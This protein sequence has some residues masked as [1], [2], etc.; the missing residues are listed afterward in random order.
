MTRIEEK[1]ERFALKYNGYGRGEKEMRRDSDG[2]WVRLSDVLALLAQEDGERVGIA[3]NPDHIHAENIGEFHPEAMEAATAVLASLLTDGSRDQENAG[4][5]AACTVSAAL[6]TLVRSEL[7]GD[8]PTGGG[9]ENSLVHKQE[10]LANPG[11]QN[12]G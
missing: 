1:L 2:G 6:Q 10:S 11:G 4:L 7:H 12:R 5:W 3:L 9:K 8:E